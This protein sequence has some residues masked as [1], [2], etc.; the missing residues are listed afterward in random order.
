MTTSNE[1]LPNGK[2]IMLRADT[3]GN[4]LLQHRQAEI[5]RCHLS[6]TGFGQ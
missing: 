4:H 1:L 2:F 5:H 3:V 6:G